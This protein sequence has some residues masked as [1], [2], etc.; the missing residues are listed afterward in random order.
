MSCEKCGAKNVA[1]QVLHNLRRLPQAL[2]LHL[3]RFKHEDLGDGR[4]RCVD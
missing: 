1:H 3:K 2:V 4:H